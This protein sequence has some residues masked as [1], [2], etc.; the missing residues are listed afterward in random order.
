MKGKMISEFGLSGYNIITN[1]LEKLE[2]RKANLDDQEDLLILEKE[3]NLELQEFVIN[4]EEM[5]E[6]LT[7]ELSLVKVATKEK[8]S[9]VDCA[10]TSI[11]GLA[12]AKDALESNISSLKVQNQ[13]LQVQ[14][15]NC[16][17]SITSSL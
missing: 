4:K 5:M 9:E 3:R 1:Q 16:K 14:F 15:E 10:K 12:K 2:K 6:A 17:N 11:V 13:E 8:E 7:K